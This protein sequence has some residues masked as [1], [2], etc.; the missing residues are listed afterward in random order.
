MALRKIIGKILTMNGETIEN[1][2]GSIEITGGIPAD[3]HGV[4]ESK[5]DVTT[6][7]NAHIKDAKGN[8]LYLPCPDSPDESLSFKMFGLRLNKFEFGLSIGDGSPIAIQTL[9]LSGGN[10]QET[11]VLNVAIDE[12]LSNYKIIDNRIEEENTER[13][14][15]R[16]IKW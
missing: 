10:V 15:W 3:M 4:F 16:E 7:I 11:N 5:Y 6:D 13:I 14:Y 8:D 1:F 12:R 2:K 9:R